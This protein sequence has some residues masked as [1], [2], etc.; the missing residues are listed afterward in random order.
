M[1]AKLPEA[2]DGW[3]DMDFKEKGKCVNSHHYKNQNY[4]NREVGL[5]SQVLKVS[6]HTHLVLRPLCHGKA[7]LPSSVMEED[8]GLMLRI[9]TPLE[10][11]PSR[12]QTLPQGHLLTPI[13]FQ[14]HGELGTEEK[15]SSHSKDFQFLMSNKAKVAPCTDL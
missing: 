11:V 14:N 12:P 8:A 7:A 10:D 5:G 9:Y 2:G 13:V 15:G 1:G 6:A 3:E 4:F